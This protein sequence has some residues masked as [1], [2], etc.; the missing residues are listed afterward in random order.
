MDREVR[1]EPDA[2]LKE[3][4]AGREEKAA[5]GGV[6]KGGVIGAKSMDEVKGIQ[7]GVKDTQEFSGI[8]SKAFADAVKRAFRDAKV[9]TKRKDGREASGKP[10]VEEGDKKGEAEGGTRDKE[11][12]NESMGLL[13]GRALKG[14]N[15]DLNRAEL[16]MGI[17]E[18][19]PGIGPI[20][21]EG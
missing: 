4:I 12:G 2:W 19:M 11:R 3:G 10:G 1:A 16:S 21:A 13:A 20:A 18:E 5:E 17:V 8:K 15:G 6:D 14:R 7:E 9:V